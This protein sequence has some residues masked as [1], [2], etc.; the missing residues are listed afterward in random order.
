[1]IPYTISVASE[2]DFSTLITPYDSPDLLPSDDPNTL[3]V[4]NKDVP[5]LG[6]D[7]IGYCCR[8]HDQK[9]CYK[10]TRFCLF[11]F[12]DKNKKFYYCHRFSSIIS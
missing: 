8:K 10:N 1:M 7:K 9:M 4:I 3:H 12:S 2:N 11:T 6:G 5:F